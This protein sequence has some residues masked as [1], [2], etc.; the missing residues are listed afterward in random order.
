ML[1]CI[2]TGGLLAIQATGKRILPGS[3]LPIDS[4]R[5]EAAEEKIDPNTASAASL[6]R[7]RG[8]GPVMAKAIVDYRRGTSR[9]AFRRPEDMA[10]VRRIG[11]GTV[12][13]I[14]PHLKFPQRDGS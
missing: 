6:R 4:R 7:L 3:L 13:K 14:A 10:N 8:I 1:L 5:V 2:L 9:P 11:P 12:K